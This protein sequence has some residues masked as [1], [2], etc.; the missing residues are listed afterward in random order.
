MKPHKTTP[1]K[2]IPNPD[3]IETV[4]KPRKQYAWLS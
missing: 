2:V 3:T 1:S 4:A